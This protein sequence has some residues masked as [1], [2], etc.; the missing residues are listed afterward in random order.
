MDEETGR[1]VSFDAAR[2]LGVLERD[3]GRRLEFHCTQ[4]A[5]GS[6]AVPVGARV[7]YRVVPGS[8]GCWEAARIEV[9]PA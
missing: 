3:D 6:R 8:L 1:V 7:R 4:I 9:V 5:D 2:G